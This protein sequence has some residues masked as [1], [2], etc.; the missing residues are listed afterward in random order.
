MALLIEGERAGSMLPMGFEGLCWALGEQQMADCIAE[1]FAKQVLLED[2]L[3]RNDIESEFIISNKNKVNPQAV[4]HRGV[5]GQD[6]RHE[7]TRS[8]RGSFPQAYRGKVRHPH[9]RAGRA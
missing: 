1:H 8:A 4:S 9:Q 2:D 6:V 5:I 7:I 3:H